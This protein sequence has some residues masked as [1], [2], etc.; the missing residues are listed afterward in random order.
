MRRFFQDKTSPQLKNFSIKVLKRESLSTAGEHT[1]LFRNK[2][3]KKHNAFSIAGKHPNLLRAKGHKAPKL[4]RE[5][6]KL[7][8][9]ALN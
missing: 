5:M 8:L 2:T 3:C 1:D 7:K 9:I 6:T 4:H